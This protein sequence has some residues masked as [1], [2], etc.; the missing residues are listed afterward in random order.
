MSFDGKIRAVS[1]IFFLIFGLVWLRL[2]Y[3]QVFQHERLSAEA[4]SQHFYTLSLPANRGEIR[5]SDGKPFVANREAFLLYA[6]LSKVP[7]N[8]LSEISDKLADILARDVPLVATDSS[9]ISAE[10]RQKFFDSTKKDLAEQFN[11]RLKIEKSIW[12]NLQHFVSRKSKNAIEALNFPGIEFTSEQARDYPEGSMSAHVA[13]FVGAD[14]IG[15]PIGYFGLEGEY[16]RELSGKVGQL[17]IEKDAFGRPIA[18]GDETVVDRRNGNTLITT[19]DRAVQLFVEK[20]LKEG[21]ETW[22]ASGGTAIVMDPNTGAILAMVSFPKYDPI[23][24]AYYDTSLYKNPAVA[25]LYEPGSIMKPLVMA[26]AINE[27]AIKPETRCDDRCNGPRR[28][29]E[30]FVHT[31]NDQYHPHLTMTETLINSDN[32]GMIFVGEELGFLK[33]YDYLK[34]FGFSKK[35]DIDL[36]EEESGDFRPQS[37]YYEIDKDTLTFGQGIVVNSVQMIKAFAAIANGG[38]LVTPHLVSQIVEPNGHVIPT[39]FATPERVITKETSQL[40]SQMLVQVAEKSPEHFPR[41]RITELNG[42]KIAAK[43]GT[44]QIAVG[45]KY[46]EKGTTASLLG[47]FPADAPRF[48]VFVKLN[49]PEVRP[50]G[51]D[52]SGPIFFSIIRDLAFHFGM[53]P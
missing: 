41:D 2:V 21:I 7:K 25:D 37:S 39:K 18:I 26:A 14:K 47:F 48:L 23:N 29:G 9:Q 36:E 1:L 5:F 43:S 34:K 15:S 27:G 11:A 19:L 28:V 52:T 8:N 17:R 33:L 4:E 30:Y 32:T 38:Y 24:F 20:N 35:S 22:K 12:V 3:W 16:D 44:A 50:W 13:G 49:E 42:F 51:S 31:F 6:N 53:T 45:G 46:K 40:V 10:D